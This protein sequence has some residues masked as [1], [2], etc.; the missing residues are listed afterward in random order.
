MAAEIGFVLP[1]NA[2]SILVSDF[3]FRDSSFRP[4]VGIG[5]VFSFTVG[6]AVTADF[7]LTRAEGSIVNIQLSI[8]NIL[9]GYYTKLFP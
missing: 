3:G 1:M 4:K 6:I 5:F 9:V 7:V 8:V 2:D